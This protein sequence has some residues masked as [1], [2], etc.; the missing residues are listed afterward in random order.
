MSRCFERKASFNAGGKGRKLFWKNVVLC[1]VEPC[2]PSQLV[3]FVTGRG[4]VSE[5][6][7]SHKNFQRI[8][9]TVNVGDVSK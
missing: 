5:I 7:F 3:F 8:F 4:K 1:H 9:S 6:A 2:L